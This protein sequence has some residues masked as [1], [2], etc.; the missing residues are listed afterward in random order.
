MVDHADSLAATALD[1]F[2]LQRGLHWAVEAVEVLTA[3]AQVTGH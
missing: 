2:H 3:E 1:P